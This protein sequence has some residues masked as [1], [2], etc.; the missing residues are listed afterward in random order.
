MKELMLHSTSKFHALCD[1]LNIPQ[2]EREN[3]QAIDIRMAVDEFTTYKLTKIAVEDVGGLVP[4]SESYPLHE[5]SNEPTTIPREGLGID[6]VKA[7]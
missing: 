3:V 7:V 5:R 2:S 6:H 4:E 1:L